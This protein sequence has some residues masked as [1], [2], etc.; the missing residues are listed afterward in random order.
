[1]V[2]CGVVWETQAQNT[3]SCSCSSFSSSVPSLSVNGFPAPTALTWRIPP[4][5]PETVEDGAV[6]PGDLSPPWAAVRGREEEAAAAGPFA[7][8]ARRSSAESRVVGTDM[9]S[10]FG[11]CQRRTGAVRCGIPCA[12]ELF[13]LLNGGIPS[14]DAGGTRKQPSLLCP[15]RIYARLSNTIFDGMISRLADFAG[16]MDSSLPL[17]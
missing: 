10:P 2:W 16:G 6:Q 8:V 7:V 1:M 17:T 13:L 15:L 12:R 11:F 14:T 9:I 3:C 5:P 4:R